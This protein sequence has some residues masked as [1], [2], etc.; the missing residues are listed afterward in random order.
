[1]KCTTAT[2]NTDLTHEIPSTSGATLVYS[3][4]IATSLFWNEIK[5]LSAFNV[6]AGSNLMIYFED[7]SGV[8]PTGGGQVVLWSGHTDGTRTVYQYEGS[9]ITKSTMAPLMRFGLG[10]V[11]DTHSV[12]MHSID[13]PK[14]IVFVNPSAQIPIVVTIKNRGITNLD[15]CYID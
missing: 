8:I 14:N 6:P 5:L 3:G 1:M 7:S 13:N 12:A 11:N 2:S 10:V 15:S 9:G 4:P